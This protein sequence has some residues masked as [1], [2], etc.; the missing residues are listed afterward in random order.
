M[1]LNPMF[2]ADAVAEYY[3]GKCATRHKELIFHEHITYEEI[4][5]NLRI[6]VC[7]CFT[8]GALKLADDETDMIDNNLFH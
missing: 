2:S 6:Q 7:T 5:G 8:L 1:E 3:Y 4:A